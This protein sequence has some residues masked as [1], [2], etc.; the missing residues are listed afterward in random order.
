MAKQGAGLARYTIVKSNGAQAEIWVKGRKQ[1][2]LEHLMRA[3]RK[4]CTPIEQP[5]PRWSGYVHKLREQGVQ[6]ETIHEP[7]A[8]DYPGTHAR[9]VL[10]CTVAQVREGGEA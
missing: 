7:H 2:A 4:G 10:R 6:I 8:G 3:G 1:W 9:Y 5:G